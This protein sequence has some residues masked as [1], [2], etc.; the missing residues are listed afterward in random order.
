MLP[1]VNLVFVIHSNR[2]KRFCIQSN[3]LKSLIC[4]YVSPLS[5]AN[6][7]PGS[8]G[9]GIQYLPTGASTAL[10]VPAVTGGALPWQ[11]SAAAAGSQIPGLALPPA[12]AAY[13]AALQ[14]LQVSQLNQ[15]HLAQA[16]VIQDVFLAERHFSCGMIRRGLVIS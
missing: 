1:I 4:Q 3:V 2:P 6:P 9:Y 5:G 11:N 15:Q 12:A 16:Q 13:A 7:S 10:N 8:A 14:N